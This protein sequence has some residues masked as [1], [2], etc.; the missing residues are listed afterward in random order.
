MALNDR[1]VIVPG[2]VLDWNGMKMKR[3]SMGDSYKARNG[4]FEWEVDAY[5]DADD[6]QFEAR[7]TYKGSLKVATGKGDT[8]FA[9]LSA[10]L[11]NLAELEA[12]IAT[13]VISR[14]AAARKRAPTV[15]FTRE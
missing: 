7:V 3:E 2:T 1:P 9:A 4:N 14:K 5:M 6:D 10:A 11:T 13:E 15:R 12:R 8:R